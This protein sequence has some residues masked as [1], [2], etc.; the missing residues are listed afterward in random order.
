VKALDMTRSENCR[1]ISDLEKWRKDMAKH[2]NIFSTLFKIT[3]LLVLLMGCSLKSTPESVALTVTPTRVPSV[4][5]EP[6]TPTPTSVQATRTPPVLTSP[7]VEGES[8]PLTL[9]S[10][11]IDRGSIT[12]L[13]D[14]A[15]LENPEAYLDLDTGEQRIAE[16][17]IRFTVSG[18]SMSFYTLE[19]VNGGRANFVGE[20]EPGVAGCQQVADS[21]S[22][23]NI[24]EIAVG[25]YLCA[26]TNQGRLA[27]LRIDK[28][29]PQGKN[30]LQ[31]SFI[32]WET[33]K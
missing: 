9:Y 19:P 5:P 13:A 17:D 30:S 3:G 8:E 33:A 10:V 7:P 29:N 32:T 11:E 1:Q 22:E 21:L 16:G 31:V 27:Q 12:L 25:H 28:V 26:E 23:G 18:G 2:H 6:I 4:T 15:L 20:E 24:P 14:P